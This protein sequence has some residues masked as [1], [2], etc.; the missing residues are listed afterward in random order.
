MRFEDWYR[1]EHPKVLGALV[2]WSGDL[3]AAS[4]ATDEAFARVLARWHRVS[5]MERPGGYVCQVALNVVRRT[6]RRRGR[7]AEL[8]SR[9]G[10]PSVEGTSAD[11]ELWDL[12]RALPERQRTAVVLRYVADLQEADI[13]SVMKVSRGT[14]ASTLSDARRA[15]AVVVPGIEEVHR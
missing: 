4:D 9:L 14:V 3:D 2:A 15:L 8:L 1:V 10:S 11:H 5:G 7:E 12:V 6:M 13:A